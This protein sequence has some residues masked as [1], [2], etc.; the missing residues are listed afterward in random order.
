[1]FSACAIAAVNESFLTS[2]RIAETAV[3]N[4]RHR[5][6]HRDPAI[7]RGLDQFAGRPAHEIIA[8]FRQPF[9]SSS[10]RVLGERLL[11]GRGVERRIERERRRL[12][13]QHVT[14]PPVMVAEFAIKQAGLPVRR[15]DPTRIEPGSLAKPGPMAR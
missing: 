14:V 9:G 2:A 10:G 15:A 11:D 1:M 3:E 6:P 5:R 13:D 7:D 4:A 8:E 12:D